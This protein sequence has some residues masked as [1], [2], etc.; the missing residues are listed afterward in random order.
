[1]TEQLE[2]RKQIIKKLYTEVLHK[3]LHKVATNIIQ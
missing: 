2:Q 3:S 1:M